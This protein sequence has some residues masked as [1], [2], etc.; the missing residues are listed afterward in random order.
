MLHL[1][2]VEMAESLEPL[3]SCRS[4]FAEGGSGTGKA[5]TVLGNCLQMGEAVENLKPLW[6][7]GR[8]G[9]ACY[10]ISTACQVEE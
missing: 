8:A 4:A 5:A 10:L 1:H 3:M 6:C 9:N 2:A 7:I